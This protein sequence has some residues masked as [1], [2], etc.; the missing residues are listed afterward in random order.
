MHESA[1]AG[2]ADCLVELDQDHPGFR[3]AAY[4]ACRNTIAR[5]ALDYEGGPVSE[6]PYTEEEHAVWEEVWR[7]LDPLHQQW[8]PRGFLV[9]HHRLGLDREQCLAAGCSDYLTKPFNW[10]ELF[11]RLGAAQSQ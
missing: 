6:V 1:H 3:D 9:L 10:S 11:E 8:A 5:A 4:C 2:G 7:S